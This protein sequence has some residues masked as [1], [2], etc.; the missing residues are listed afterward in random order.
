MDVATRALNDW[1]DQLGAAC[2]IADVGPDIDAWYAD[3]DGDALA[4]RVDGSELLTALEQ[5]LRTSGL[6]PG[7]GLAEHL[8]AYAEQHEPPQSFVDEVR[9]LFKELETAWPVR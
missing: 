5:E 2:E 9:A 6:L 4:T 7:G 3:F 8:L 1:A